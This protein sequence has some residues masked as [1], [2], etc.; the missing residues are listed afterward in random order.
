MNTTY[1]AYHNDEECIICTPELEEET[2]RVY[3]TEGGRD[4]E[5]YERYTTVDEAVNVR[6]RTLVD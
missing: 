3:F 5:D 4:L 1:V 2:I 6:T